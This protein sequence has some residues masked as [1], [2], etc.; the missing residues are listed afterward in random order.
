MALKTPSF[1]SQLGLFGG[2]R[3]SSFSRTKHAPGALI[4]WELTWALGALY[5]GLGI[6]IKHIFL[7][8]SSQGPSSGVTEVLGFSQGT[9]QPQFPVIHFSQKKF[10][11]N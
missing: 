6:K 9:G 10:K 2:Q 3:S 5:R 11:G 1:E 8:L 7:F 4:T